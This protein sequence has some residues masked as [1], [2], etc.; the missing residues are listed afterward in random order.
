MVL[1]TLKLYYVSRL[2]EHPG[3]A[4]LCAPVVASFAP[5][6]CHCHPA[7][8][9]TRDISGPFEISEL[10]AEELV[11]LALSLSDEKSPPDQLVQWYPW[12]KHIL[13]FGARISQSMMTSEV[14]LCNMAFCLGTIALMT[15]ICFC[16][17]C[18]QIS[19]NEFNTSA[20]CNSLRHIG[21]NA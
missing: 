5:G 7:F 8:H 13:L 17:K 9:G 2:F 1:E 19:R 12:T 15:L 20:P 10:S 6:G 11:D 21:L 4:C 3:V 16:L 18:N 14:L